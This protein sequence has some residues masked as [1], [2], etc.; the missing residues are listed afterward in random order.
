MKQHVKL[1]EEFVEQQNKPTKKFIK[2]SGYVTIE[3]WRLPNGARHRED[4][5][6]ILTYDKKVLVKQEW[7]INNRL[8]REDGPAITE[9]RGGM[10]IRE[11]WYVNSQHY[12]ADGPAVIM[13]YEKHELRIDGIDDGKMHVKREQWYINNELGRTGGPAEIDY[14]VNGSIQAERWFDEGKQSRTDGPAVIRYAR[15]GEVIDVEWHINGGRLGRNKVMDMLDADPDMAKT[16]KDIALKQ[17][18]YNIIR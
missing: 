15:D 1:F 10:P 16:Y 3:E 2:G 12:R 17:K 7:W 13:Y 9:Y 6:A 14:Y 11:E 5:P 4:G 18:N 8:Q